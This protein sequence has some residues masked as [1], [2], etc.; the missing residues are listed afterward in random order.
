[1]G[2]NIRRSRFKDSGFT[3]VRALLNYHFFSP[4]RFLGENKWGA[5]KKNGETDKTWTMQ[6]VFNLRV[7]WF[8]VHI[9]NSSRWITL[10]LV[11]H[12]RGI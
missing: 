3:D 4:L 2:W 1:M 12:G 10:I 7:Q 9:C 6:N 5:K 8:T 11:F